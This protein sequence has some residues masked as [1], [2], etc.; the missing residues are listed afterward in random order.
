MQWALLGVIQGVDIGPRLDQGQSHLRV[1]V[2]LRCKMERGLTIYEIACH[3]V[4]SR[5][6]NDLRDTVVFAPRRSE[7]KWRQIG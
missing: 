3:Y 7:M 5:L 2:R 6:D 1:L 4:G